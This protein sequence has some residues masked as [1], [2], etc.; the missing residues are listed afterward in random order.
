MT[1]LEIA[2]LMSGVCLFLAVFILYWMY[3]LRK[4]AQKQ[5]TKIVAKCGHETALNGKVT[6]YSESITTEIKPNKDGTV[7]YCHKCLEKMAIRC[8]WCKKPIFIGD[9]IT[10]YSPVEVNT[11]KL[12]EF[13]VIYN[14]ERMQIVGC[15]RTTC[16]ESGADYC[17]TWIPGE[18][19]VGQVERYNS[20]IEQSMLDM[21]KGGN[22]AVIR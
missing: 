8:G 11:Y 10:L 4:N 16:A 5:T 3:S 22:G 20:A 15:E 12:P 21:Q 18:N 17:G 13:A 9:M 7:D 1:K 19:Y 14:K 2:Y 6:A